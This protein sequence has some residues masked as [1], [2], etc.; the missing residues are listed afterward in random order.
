MADSCRY[1]D[2]QRRHLAVKGKILGRKMLDELAGIVT[3][4]AILRWHPELAA[5]LPFFPR[6]GGLHHRYDWQH[7]A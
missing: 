1:H 7:A 5:R 4:D 6:L 2:D 3:P